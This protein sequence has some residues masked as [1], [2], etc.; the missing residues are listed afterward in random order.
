MIELASRVAVV[1]GA[2]G[3]MGRQHALLLA[4]RGA[5][6]VVND[7]GSDVHGQGAASDAA[8]Q[9]VDEIV[10]AGGEAVANGDGVHTWEGGQR[11]VAA[12]VD[13]F[14][15][16]DI[17]VNNAGIL[18]DTSFGKLDEAALDAV[19]KVHLY[20]AFHVARA[21]W[22]HMKEAGYG[23]IVN[24]SSG[25]GLYGN[26]GQSNY[27]AA[28]AGLVGL[29][30]ALAIEGARNGILVNAIAP[31]AASRMTESILPHPLLERL[32]PAYVSPLVVYLVSDECTESGSVF[33]VGGGYY[34]RVAM[35]EGT[36]AV[37]DTVPDPEQLAASFPRIRALEGAAELRGLSDQV[38]RMAAA[39][40][41]EID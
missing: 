5:R 37:F 4:S 35:V 13:A 8:Q 20:G 40:G 11:I 9:V 29:T 30:R 6:V 23:R 25:S 2:G 41:I 36:G 33:S 17:V 16:C 15:S 31:L 38:D 32:D 12:A 28:K 21:A 27:A 3:G 7:L 19:V 34:A 39:L 24:T 22:P 26:F 14:G 10:A 1:T 18:R